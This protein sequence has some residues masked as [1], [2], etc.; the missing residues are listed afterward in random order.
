LKS[1]SAILQEEYQRAAGKAP[2]LSVHS[3]TF[4]WANLRQCRER[5]TAAKRKSGGTIEL[6]TIRGT[7][8]MNQ[9]D[10]SLVAAGWMKLLGKK[11]KVDAQRAQGVSSRAGLQWIQESED[12]KGQRLL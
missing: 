7:T 11:S 8:H 10:F 5:F 9:S 4:E 1:F 6:L 3:E 12:V 2:V